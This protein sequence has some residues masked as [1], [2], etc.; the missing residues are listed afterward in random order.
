MQLFYFHYFYI[1]SKRHRLTG[2]L[3]QGVAPFSVKTPFR[4]SEEGVFSSEVVLIGLIFSRFLIKLCICEAKIIICKI[5]TF[6]I[7]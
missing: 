5:I 3:L 1:L 7:T 4:G 2:T 6:I